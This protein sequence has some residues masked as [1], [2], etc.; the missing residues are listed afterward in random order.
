MEK[1][2]DGV[3][4]HRIIA[5]ALRAFGI[6]KIMMMAIQHYTL[7]GSAY[8]EVTGRAD[9]LKTIK[10]SSEQ[11]DPFQYS[12]P[13]CHGTSKH[14]FG[15]LFSGIDLLHRGGGHCWPPFIC[16]Q[17]TISHVWYLKQLTISA[18]PVPI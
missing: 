14:I 10:T 18:N 2:F 3:V 12:L 9:I 17:M 13:Y 8:V 4:G 7:V 5:Q 11:G 16:I 6:P 15:L 1:A